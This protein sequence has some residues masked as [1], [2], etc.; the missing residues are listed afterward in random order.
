MWWVRTPIAPLPVSTAVAV[1]A[2]VTPGV[3]S[4]RTRAVSAPR[5]SATIVAASPSFSG[6][7]ASAA[8]ATSPLV[9]LKRRAMT[10]AVV[11][12]DAWL[13]SPRPALGTGRLVSVIITAAPTSQ[14]VAPEIDATLVTAAWVTTAAGATSGLVRYSSASVAAASPWRAVPPPICQVPW[15]GGE[16]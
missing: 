14:V 1:V 15:P 7:S 5:A 4:K 6:R 11:A 13:T 9:A 12:V 3:S 2:R 16:A 8:L 10:S